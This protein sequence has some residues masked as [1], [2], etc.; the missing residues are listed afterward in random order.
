MVSG[1]GM[2]ALEFDSTNFL[3]R[4]PWHLGF[5]PIRELFELRVVP[6]FVD[7]TATFGV[8]VWE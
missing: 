6:L 4:I 5:D 2:G 7:H 3:R 1:G 8:K